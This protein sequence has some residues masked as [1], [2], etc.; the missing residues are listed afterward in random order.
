MRPA[1]AALLSAALVAALVAALAIGDDDRPPDRAQA[2]ATGRWLPL[3]SAGLERSEVAA[4][5]IGHAIYV[6]GGFERTSGGATTAAVERYDIR[7]DRWRRVRSMPVALNHPA[8]AAHGG[9]LYVSGGYR[10]E[11]SLAS[12]SRSLF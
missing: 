7:R 2:T 6:L 4:A 9:R 5:R 8:A 12:P 3:A 1:L 11:Q 10:A